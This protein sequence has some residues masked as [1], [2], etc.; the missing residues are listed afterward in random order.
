MKASM[1]GV[2]NFSVLDGWFDEAVDISGGW[3]IGDRSPYSEEQNEMHARTIYSTLENDIVP[4]FYQGAEEELPL[5][6][7]RR[8]KTCLANI[9][10]RFSCGRMVLEY[11]NNLYKPAHHL[12]VDISEGNFKSAEQRRIGTTVC[13]TPGTR[14]DSSILATARRIM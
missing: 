9:T 14:F 6:W 2:L 11:M 13:V 10:P 3:A 5:E 4:L 7:L 8:M 1:N 12:W